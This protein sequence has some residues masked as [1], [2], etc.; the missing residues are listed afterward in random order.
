MEG[1]R[2]KAWTDKDL[3]EYELRDRWESG[4]IK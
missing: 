3:E 4:E 2:N 1:K